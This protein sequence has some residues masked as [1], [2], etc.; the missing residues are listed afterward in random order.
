V[1]FRLLD[2][3]LAILSAGTDQDITITREAFAC[4]DLPAETV[5]ITENEINFFAFPQVRAS[6]VI[7]GAGYG[8]RNLAD[9]DWLQKRKIYYWEDIDTHGF[10]ILDQFREFFPRAESFLMARETLLT[11]RSLWETENQPG[12]ATLTRLT[13]EEKVLYDDLCHNMLG[14][15]IRL[16]QEK[17]AFNTLVEAL[18]NIEHP[19]F[20]AM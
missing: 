5:F 6:M 12:S 11:H 2:P 3:D 15:R 8:F 10:A 1:R 9:I 13:P 4:I 18:G 17:I 20:Q 14:N 7:F 19:P 16:E